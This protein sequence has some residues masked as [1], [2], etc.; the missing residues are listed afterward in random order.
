MKLLIVE[1]PTKAKHIQHFLGS[2]WQVKASLGHVRD[3]VHTGDASY[4]RPPEFKMNYQITDDKH[5]EIVAGLKSAASKADSVYLAMDPDREGEAIAWHLAQ[6]LGIKAATAHRVTYQE[7]TEAAVLKAVAT[8][9]N[10]NMTL[11]AAQETRRALDRIVGWE[12]S[13]PL[14]RSLNTKASAGR[15]QTPALRLIVER[16]RAIRKFKSTT[17]YQV[18]AVMPGVDGGLHPA[19][20]WRATWQ[21]GMPEG[22]YFQDKTF[23]DALAVALPSMPLIVTAA[24]SKPARQAPPPPFTT[25]SLQMDASRALKIDAE[26]VMKLAQGLFEKGM[27]TYH[28]TDSPNLS[29]EGEDLLR[30]EAQRR[31]WP[32][33]EKPRRWKAKGD[34]Q[35]AHEAI[36]P[37]DASDLGAELDAQ[38]KALYGLIWKRA[39]ASQLAD[40]IYQV[41][42]ATLDGGM[43]QNRAVI[44]KATGR[45]LTDKGWRRLYAESGDGDEGEEKDPEAS[46][47]VPSLTKG[48][49]LTADRAEA[50]EKKTQP[51]KR[52]TQATLIA[53]L[54]RHG[55]GR[56]S[57]YAS[58]IK[59]LFFRTYIEQKQVLVPTDLG[60]RA[61]DALLPF[62]F[63]D[64]DY[65]REIEE[66]LDRIAQGQAKGREL[67]AKA[68]ADLQETLG[69]M[70]AG[71]APETAPCPVEGCGG[72]VRRLESKKKPGA[73]FWAC[74]NREAHGL[75]QDADGQPGKPFE[76]R[77]A[78]APE[79]QGPDCPK[80]KQPTGQFSTS[81]GKPY[82]RCQKCSTAWWPDKAAASMA[83]AAVLGE[84]WKA[85]G[86]KG[87]GKR[88]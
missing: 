70:P 67:L 33:S 27:I 65:T 20:A 55:V 46:N 35:E 44:F 43:F 2:G 19:G 41:T 80:C 78:K 18:Q 13:P 4:V 32:L 24:E 45:V 42:T 60:E 83:D 69:A 77:Q 5:K 74:S 53:E 64:V 71:S 87:K 1:S 6:V 76:E 50:V 66:T 47:P 52:F 84:K 51:P 72:S 54:E 10:I 61:I 11:V 16:E 81:T 25:S 26:Q 85:M 30:G 31:N 57:T 56:P 28:R 40:A 88:G 63:C 14:S 68:Y 21:D 59:V 82:Y 36:R 49:A 7:V 39:M 8:P 3:L 15:V 75:L 12:V 38:E 58:I 62:H 9:R 48:A 37:T 86:G 22:T 34:A 23:A 73:C 17:W 29:Q 79:A